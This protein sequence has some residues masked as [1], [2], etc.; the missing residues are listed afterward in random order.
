MKH[1]TVPS[2]PPG[3]SGVSTWSSP[4]STAWAQVDRMTPPLTPEQRADMGSNI[5]QELHA[6][7]LKVQALMKAQDE[8]FNAMMQTVLQA[9]QNQQSGASVDAKIEIV[10]SD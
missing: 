4:P 2:T 6:M 1:Q 9:V 5:G 8:R 3:R 7:E 10:D